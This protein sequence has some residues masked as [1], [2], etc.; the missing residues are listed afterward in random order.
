MDGNDDVLR[1]HRAH[2]YAHEGMMPGGVAKN[3]LTHAVHRLRLTREAWAE[4]RA[5]QRYRAD[6]SWPSA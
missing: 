1:L 6:F 4:K 3:G 2:G 5:F